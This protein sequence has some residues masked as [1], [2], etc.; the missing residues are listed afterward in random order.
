MEEINLRFVHGN[1]DLL[2]A[3]QFENLVFRPRSQGGQIQDFQIQGC[4][5]ACLVTNWPKE[6]S[7]PEHVDYLLPTIDVGARDPL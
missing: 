5:L 4:Q 1:F 2:S 7:G 6:P 3:G